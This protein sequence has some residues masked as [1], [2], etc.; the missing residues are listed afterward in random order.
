M[1][2]RAFFKLRCNT[3]TEEEYVERHK[4]VWP[5]VQ[6]DLRTAGVLEMSIWMKVRLSAERL[7]MS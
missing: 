4:N 2:E 5:A 6:T 7:L 1:P 3:G